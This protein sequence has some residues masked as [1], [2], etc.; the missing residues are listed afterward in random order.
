MEVVAARILA[1]LSVPR[2]QQG[3]GLLRLCLRELVIGTSSLI[4]ADGLRSLLGVPHW[5]VTEAASLL[6]PPLC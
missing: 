2:L 1:T 5:G 6:V 4:F 3:T